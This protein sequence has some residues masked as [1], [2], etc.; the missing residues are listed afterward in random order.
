MTEDL[1]PG[2]S[3]T[4]AAVQ[5][6]VGVQGPTIPATAI[7]LTHDKCLFPEPAYVF[8]HPLTQQAAYISLLSERAP[9]P[10]AK[11]CAETSRPCC[12][13]LEQAFDQ[14]LSG[15]T[16]VLSDIAQ[17][18]GQGTNA[19]ARVARNRDVVLAAFKGGQPKMATG[20]TGHPVARISKRAREI[21]AGEI[22]RQPQAVMT[23]SRTK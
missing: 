2:P 21:I 23:S 9:P 3:L 14:C 7:E 15:Q 5:P 10:Q 13:S 12:L 4:H 19:E 20:L 11:G 6:A 17:H 16:E 22:P 8:Q 18:A 1:A